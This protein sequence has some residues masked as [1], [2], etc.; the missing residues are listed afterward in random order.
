MSTAYEER[1]ECERGD[2]EAEPGPGHETHDETLERWRQDWHEEL[3]H[4][5]EDER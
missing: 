3:E 2:P 4:D 5:F 1:R